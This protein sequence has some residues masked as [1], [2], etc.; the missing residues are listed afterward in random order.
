MPGNSHIDNIPLAK[1]TSHIVVEIADYTPNG[2]ASTVII[3]KTTGEVTTMAFEK[4]TMLSEK[5]SPF[6]R[7]I[8][9]LEGMAE[10]IIEKR[11]NRV[12][13]GRAIIIPAH[14][15]A[16]IEQATERFK[17]MQTVIKSGYEL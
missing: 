11:I 3:K 14:T 6:D 13:T 8:L 16:S 2:I 10:I 5:T 4:D 17:I 7:F 15:P 12:A 1:A 9:V